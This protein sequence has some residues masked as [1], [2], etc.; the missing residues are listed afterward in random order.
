[1]L[2]SL[3]YFQLFRSSYSFKAFIE[4]SIWVNFPTIFIFGKIGKH[5]IV[6]LSFFVTANSRRWKIV[7]I[8][9]RDWCSRSHLNRLLFMCECIKVE[10]V[11]IFKSSSYDHVFTLSNTL[12]NLKLAIASFM[13]S[14]TL[15]T[16]P[17]LYIFK[18]LNNIL[19]LNEVNRV[20]H[21]ILAP[22]F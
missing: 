21:A 19:D 9:I 10:L 17:F 6:F 11:D 2:V 13:S 18:F 12:I 15:S 20:F 3:D 22:V 14:C 4:I 1:M 7:A 5:I 16:S 8:G